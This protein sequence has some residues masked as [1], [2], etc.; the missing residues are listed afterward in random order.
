MKLQAFF[1]A[2]A[3]ATI[4]VAVIGPTGGSEAHGL[5]Q[6]QVCAERCEASR[7]YCD[8]KCH[9]PPKDAKNA[10]EST[11]DCAKKCEVNPKHETV[12]SFTPK[13]K[14]CL[15]ACISK[16]KPCIEGCRLQKRSCLARCA[17]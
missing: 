7:E 3:I 11:A 17:T 10:K 5:G 6:D 14:A 16:A 13:E 4:A 12:A 1:V 2:G 8:T 15:K 9:E